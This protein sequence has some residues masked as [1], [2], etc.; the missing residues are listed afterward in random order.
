M[1]QNICFC[2][3]NGGQAER[4]ED[5]CHISQSAG[6]E[7][8][9]PTGSADLEICALAEAERSLGMKDTKTDFRP[10]ITIFFI[11]IFK[12][13]KQHEGFTGLH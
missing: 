2:V 3:R 7:A 12:E 5:P 4:S 8:L 11:S 1:V 9:S 6:S 13:E 10:H